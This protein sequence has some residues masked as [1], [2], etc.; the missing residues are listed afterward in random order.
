MRG[1]RPKPTALHLLPGTFRK[2]RHGSRIDAPKPQAVSEAENN[3]WK[4]IL[5]LPVGPPRTR[6][7]DPIEELLERDGVEIRPED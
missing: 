4:A 6:P 3:V 2:D 7:L 1:R 5:K